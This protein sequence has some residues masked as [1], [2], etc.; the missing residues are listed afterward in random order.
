[1]FVFAALV[2][3]LFLGVLL[4]IE[5]WRFEPLAGAGVVSALPL[6][7]I[8]VRP[9]GRRVGRAWRAGAGA[10][11]LAGGLVALAWMPDATAGYLAA[12]LAVCGCG[13][14]LATSVLG[15]AAVQ[16]DAGLVRS[17]GRSVAARHAGLVL[18]LVLIA[19]VLA[20]SLDQATHQAT[21]AGTGALLDAEVSLQKK[22]PLAWEV[23]NEIEDTPAARSPTSRRRSNA[24][25]RATT[26]T[27]PP[28]NPP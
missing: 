14:G 20:G 22:I 2:G 17:A 1:M 11:L 9:L 10:A 7:A 26:P 4:V 21:L 13:L 28:P 18:G 6:G 19:P 24:R 8:A 5:V 15:P 3:A 16:A 27:W 12:A 23:R 25:A